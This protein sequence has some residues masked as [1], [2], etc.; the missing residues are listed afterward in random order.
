MLEADENPE[1]LKSVLVSHMN[2][3]LSPNGVFLHR[4][5]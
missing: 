3:S 1:K 4:T 5:V 2:L